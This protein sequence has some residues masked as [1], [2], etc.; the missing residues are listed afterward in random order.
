M[1]NEEKI[2][3]LFLCTGNS[4]RSQMAEAWARQL[5]G[6]GIEGYSAGVSPK[7][8]DP[9][10]VRAM[11]EAGIDISGQRSKSVDDLRGITFDYVITLCDHAQ[12]SCPAFPGGV[13][14]VHVGFEDPPQ[15]AKGAR[16]EEEAMGHY[17]RIRDEIR[18]FVERLP[19]ALMGSDAGE[20]GN[21]QSRF[22]IGI[23][24]FLSQLPGELRGKKDE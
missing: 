22:E 1:A 18:V 2:R 24:G 14:V 16:S 17:R 20:A 11:A 3:I 19:Q 6:D 21:H 15:L 23:K 8:I 5:K 9:R 13:K 12:Q 10:A 4:C 7:G